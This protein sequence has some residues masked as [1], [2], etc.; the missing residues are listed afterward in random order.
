MGSS[1]FF[2]LNYYTSDLS[3]PNY[4]LN[5]LNSQFT[6]DADKGTS[7]YQ[8]ATWDVQYNWVINAPNGLYQN[9]KWIWKKYQPKSIIITETGSAEPAEWNQIRDVGRVRYIQEH[10]SMTKVSKKKFSQSGNRTRAARVRTWN[11]NH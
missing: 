5:Y 11:P 9:L 2:G 3:T 6:Y 4:D 10:L 7:G 8:D 1:D